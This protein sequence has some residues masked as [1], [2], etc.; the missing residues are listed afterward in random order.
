MATQ[1]VA[2]SCLAE[3]KII[4]TCIVIAKTP[5]LVLTLGQ[6]QTRA[7]TQAVN[8]TH[9]AALVVALAAT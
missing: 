8:M 9:Q 3:L 1:L 7:T 6:A 5:G 4:V 2:V